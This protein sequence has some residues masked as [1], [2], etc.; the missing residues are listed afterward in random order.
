MVK[1]ICPTFAAIRNGALEKTADIRAFFKTR[2]P[3][4][5]CLKRK[6]RCVEVDKETLGVIWD[7]EKAV[8]LIQP[9]QKDK[10]ANAETLDAIPIHTT[11]YVPLKY[12]NQAILAPYIFHIECQDGEAVHVKLDDGDFVET[13][14]YAKAGRHACDLWQIAHHYKVERHA[15]ESPEVAQALTVQTGNGEDAMKFLENDITQLMPAGKLVCLFP[16]QSVKIFPKSVYVWNSRM[17]GVRYADLPAESFEIRVKNQEILTKDSVSA[18]MGASCWFTITDPADAIRQCPEF[19]CRWGEDRSM[20]EQSLSYKMY[21]MIMTKLR[22][23]IQIAMRDYVIDK[24]ID[25][26]VHLRH[27]FSAY[28][29][30][31][32]EGMFASQ[33]STL[34]RFG[35][36]IDDAAVVDIAIPAE[37]KA[38]NQLL[39]INEKKSRARQIERKDEINATRTLLNTAKLLD[40]NENLRMLKKLEYIEKIC[41]NNPNLQI[42]LNDLKNI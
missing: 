22:T 21:D 26:L 23:A 12:R 8:R 19:L 5:P 15:I 31:S 38:A 24:T 3:A 17:Q 35:L 37:I 6:S 29:R 2:L 32:L 28:L 16:D 25:E 1:S 39:L 41:V 36:R 34:Y 13:T 27:E 33:T 20:G 42:S 7:H 40:E 14:V 10:L 9:G 4:L 18:R 30:T 11:H